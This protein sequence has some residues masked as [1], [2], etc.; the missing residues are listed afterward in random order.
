MRLLTLVLFTMAAP[1]FSGETTLVFQYGQNGYIGT[2]DTYVSTHNWDT[3]PQHTVNYG[4]N[5]YVV[6]SRN[7]GDNPIV[8]FDLS[9]IPSNSLILEATLELYNTTDASGFERR[10]RVYEVLTDWD[11]GNQVESPI[12]ASGKRGATGDMAFDFFPGEGTDVAWTAQGMGEGSD[13]ES[14][15]EDH[16]DVTDSGW[17]QWDLTQMV[18]AWVRLER[19]NYGCVLRDGTGYVAGNPDWRNFC[20]SQYADPNL[21]PRLV[22]RYNPDVPFAS[23][24]PDVELLNWDGS[25][26]QLDGSASV[27]RPGG[28]NATLQY[29]WDIIQAGYNSQLSGQIGSQAL[30]SFQPDVPGDWVFQL[31]VTNEIMETSTDQVRY[32]LLSIPASH[33]RIYLTPEKLTTLQAR[34]VPGNTRWTQLEDEASQPDGSMHAKALVGLVSSDNALCDEAVAAAETLMA[35]PGDW[36][37]KAGDIA[38][39]FDW[40]Y[41]RLSPTQISQFVNYFNS[42]G[43]DQL[44]DPF[45]SDT[46]GWGNYWPRYGYSFALIGLASFGDNA[47]AQEWFD[48]F[49]VWRFG[50]NDL[51]ILERIAKGGG[52]PEGMIYDWI[53]NPPRV[54]ALEAWLTATGENLFH[55]TTW[56]EE[57]LPFILI[58]RWPGLASEWG[59]DYHPYAGIGD[60]E[61]NRG[62]IGNYERIMALILLEKFPASSVSSQLQ[63]YLSAGTTANSDDFLFHEEFLWYNPDLPQETPNLQTHWVEDLGTVILRSNWPSGAVDDDPQ[64]TH[65]TFQCG[66]HYTY[67]QH[68]DQNSFTLFKYSDL[69]LDS[70]VYSGDGLSYHD[71]DYYVRTIAHNTLIVHNPDED[72]AASRPGAL[73]VD[74][75]QRSV[76]PATRSPQSIE[77]FDQHQV[78]YE[79]GD[80]LQFEDRNHFTYMLGDA[81]AAYNNPQ[82]NQAMDT[83]LSDNV[84]KVTRFKRSLVYLRRVESEMAEQDYVVLLDRVGVTQAAYSGS[85]TK[86]LFHTFNEPAIDGNAQVVSVGETLHTQATQAEAVNGSGKLYIQSVWPTEIQMRKV[87]GRA[88]KAFWVFDQNVDWHWSSGE[89]QPR[90]TSDFE[91]EPYGEWRI[92]I[93]PVDSALDH[94]FL[95]VLTPTSSATPSA[96]E[97]A[98]ISGTD[99]RGVLI[100][101]ADLNRVCIFSDHVDGDPV[102]GGI[103]YQL[104]PS[105]RTL[106]TLFDLPPLASYDLV[107]SYPS[108]MVQIELVPNVL[109]ALTASDQGVLEFFSD[110]EGL[111]LA[112]L[113]GQLTSWPEQSI[114]E[115]IPLACP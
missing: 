89:P 57:R 19:P 83:A 63:A 87:G 58:H 69:L 95:N 105:A 110:L 41:H 16:T 27:D 64:A 81:T 32:R 112:T 66:D 85:N 20:S 6:L 18:T 53:A 55:S 73:T 72:F 30:S 113:L 78:H 65:L 93:E 50:Q 111:C 42:W 79:T 68:F 24:G 51:D 45:S 2:S 13:Y 49:R 5:Q 84:A 103:L 62:A 90:P 7:A 12:D 80:I 33:P 47:R 25:N 74:G 59:Y 23:A 36:S 44:D 40:C 101:D 82:Y 10:V 34:A 70:G 104:T 92:E 76:Y 75:G 29:R 99:I 107:I 4:Q 52:W 15:E 108:G 22:V 91:T 56:F 94:E 102:P 97:V 26:I 114:L 86:L 21:R 96:T 60:S 9:S 46:P 11:E 54:R 88:E 71:R 77:Y 3:P 43:Q 1:L 37:T 31:T 8:K 98:A 67:H 38:L 109:G 61:R 106:H 100:L 115:L 48:H 39:V 17:Y 35:T 28:N 14:L